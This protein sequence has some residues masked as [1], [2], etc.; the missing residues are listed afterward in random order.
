MGWE[1]VFNRWSSFGDV[2][3]GVRG[4]VQG[5]GFGKEGIVLVRYGEL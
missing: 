3:A 1:I 5:F 2:M 4:L